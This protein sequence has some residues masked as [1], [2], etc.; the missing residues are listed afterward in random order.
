MTVLN[1]ERPIMFSCG[2][3]YLFQ[4]VERDASGAIVDFRRPLAR[5]D[6]KSN[7]GVLVQVFATALVH[8]PAGAYART[9]IEII[10]PDGRTLEQ[11]RGEDSINPEGQTTITAEFG[12]L[13]I[14][15]NGRYL[16]RLIING[17][18][19]GTCALLVARIS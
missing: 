13:A 7:A 4:E 19:V 16:F 3:F 14:N 11:V 12:P 10:Q 15:Q 2:G 8:G 17:E 18:I 6:R 1:S 5:I 9:R